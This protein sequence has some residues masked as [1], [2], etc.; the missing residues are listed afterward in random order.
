MLLMRGPPFLASSSPQD[1]SVRL[2]DKGLRDSPLFRQGLAK[3]LQM[4]DEARG[5]E[6]F[7]Q[8]DIFMKQIKFT[9]DLERYAAILLECGG[10]TIEREHNS[11][12][13][14]PERLRGCF[15]GDDEF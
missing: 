15:F 1:E 5:G 3:S 13:T 2:A 10:K 4:F 14:I 9:V 6:V 12:R 7:V 8:S 11:A